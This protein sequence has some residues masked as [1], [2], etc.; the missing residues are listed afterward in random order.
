MPPKGWRKNADGSYPQ[1][2][3]EIPQVSID[4]LLFPRSTIQKLSKQIV[5][6]DSLISKDSL[7]ALQRAATVFVSHLLFHSKDVVKE[8]NRKTINSQD[9]LNALERSEFGGFIPLIKEKLAKF[10][11]IQRQKKL[12]KQQAGI[13]STGE[14]EDELDENINEIEEINAKKARIQDVYM[15]PNQQQHVQLPQQHPLQFQQQQHQSQQQQQQA[16]II[17]DGDESLSSDDDDDEIQHH[18][19]H[20]I[21]DEDEI[22]DDD[23]DE[24][25][26]EDE[27]EEDHQNPIQLLSKDEK[28][29]QGREETV[30]DVEEV[31]DDE[32]DTL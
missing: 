13:P 12:L 3:R 17:D 26:D 21:D 4:E 1:P 18:E 7:I 22:E 6:E 28:E 9:V 19:V 2:Q 20:V 29:L 11:E 14:I 23:E 25:E 31:D 16:Q 8:S 24:D 27:E 15:I 10:E 30:S 32:D 5:T